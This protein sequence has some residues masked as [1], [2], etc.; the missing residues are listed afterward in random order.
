M[1]KKRC[2]PLAKYPQLLF[3]QIYIVVVPLRPISSHIVPYPADDIFRR[4]V[5]HYESVYERYPSDI[6]CLSLVAGNTVQEQNVFG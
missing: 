1:M 6:P 3:D 2:C 5:K 4:T